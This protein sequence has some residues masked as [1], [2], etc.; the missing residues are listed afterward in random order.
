[1]KIGDAAREKL[2]PI[3]QRVF[4]WGD[5][6]AWLDLPV[7]FVAQVMMFG[8]DEDKATVAELLG[9]DA[10]REVLQ[11]PPPGVFN[12][13]T[14][15]AWHQR[16]KLLVRPLPTRTFTEDL[17][18]DPD[19]KLA[20]EQAFGV[21]IAGISGLPLAEREA[22]IERIWALQGESPR[23]RAWP[24]EGGNEPESEPGWDPSGTYRLDVLR[25][26]YDELVAAGK[27]DPK[28]TS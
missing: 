12:V 5:R 27:I 9:E 14:W 23:D 1:M 8:S 4:W 26:V 11:N 7:R 25:Q 3:A 22:A 24:T 2:L 17:I 13:E 16:F 21:E 6:A 18:S 19:Y 10:F 28:K 20:L 15:S